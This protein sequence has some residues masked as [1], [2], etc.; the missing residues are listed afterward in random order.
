MADREPANLA[1][2]KAALTGT[3][4]E[5]I[6][7]AGQQE[8]SPEEVIQTAAFRKEKIGKTLGRFILLGSA[9]PAIAFWFYHAH[10]VKLREAKAETAKEEY[11]KSVVAGVINTWHADDHCEDSLS[12]PGYS[13]RA[14]YTVELE[15]ALI[16]DRP[17]VVFGS[18]DDVSKSGQSEDS[19]VSIW[20]E[21]RA[22]LS[23]ALRLSLLCSPEIANAI[24]GQKD[25]ASEMFVFAVKINSV[26]KI[27]MP[28][29]SSDPDYFL[30]HGVLYASKPIGLDELPAQSVESNH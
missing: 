28:S 6:T 7:K 15:K 22:N 10:E 8:S 4:M 12:S 18:V 29:N 30:A 26:E 19:I 17:L 21:T 25:R 23:P 3:T 20:T 11:A 2:A 5:E 14:L 16:R 24:L 13:S 9:A 1:A 27:S